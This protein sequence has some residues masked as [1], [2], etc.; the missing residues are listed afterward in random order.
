MPGSS[1]PISGPAS[2]A[3]GSL[4]PQAASFLAVWPSARGSDTSKAAA[5]SVEHATGTLRATVLGVIK[6]WGAHGA[7][8]D[9]VEL[10]TG[11]THQT[12]SARINELHKLSAINDSGRR[13]K[14]RSGRNAIVWVAVKEERRG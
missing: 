8:C 6:S 13:R 5:E 4:N 14:T 9:E 10:Y 1:P 12:A 11:L 7:T 3:V 2:A